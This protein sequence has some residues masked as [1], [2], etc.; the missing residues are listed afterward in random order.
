MI[1]ITMEIVA[2]E[3]NPCY[4]DIYWYNQDR[5]KILL[6]SS[7]DFLFVGDFLKMKACIKEVILLPNGIIIESRDLKEFWSNYV[8]KVHDTCG[9][10]WADIINIKK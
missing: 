9:L 1:L 2:V 7:V 8:K 4:Y 5:K 3:N 6:Q 10:P